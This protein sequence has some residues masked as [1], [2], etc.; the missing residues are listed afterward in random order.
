M[1]QRLTK[2]LR[3]RIMQMR[4]TEVE[5]TDNVDVLERNGDW[6]LLYNA[7]LMSSLL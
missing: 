6:C 7:I 5:T 2:S 3:M 4:M 1:N